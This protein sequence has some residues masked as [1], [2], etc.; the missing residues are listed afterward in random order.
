MD[1][2]FAK[3]FFSLNF[4]FLVLAGCSIPKP[5]ISPDAVEKYRKTLKVDK[6]HIQISYL[7]NGD[8]N[9][10][11][12]VM[13]HGT[14][15]AST[16]WAD[17]IQ[18][19]PPNSKVIAIDRPGFGKS[20]SS[21]SFSKLTDQVAA[22]HQIIP[23]NE[24]KITLIGH[25]LGGPIVAMYAAKYPDQV[26][27]VILLAGSFDPALEK[28]HP[29][30]YFADWF[31]VSPVLPNHIRNANEEL[32]ALKSELEKLTPLLSQIKAKI[33]IVHGDNDDLVPVDNVDFLKNHLTS[34]RCVETII[35]KGQNHFLPWNSE[36]IVRKAMELARTQ[37][38]N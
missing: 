24:S 5:A 37:V 33:I 12:F 28:I 31:L 35:I 11:L 4:L 17:Y 19:P 27:A 21:H 1:F 32:M 36:E 23:A 2:S 22:L 6:D 10:Q 9:G 26:Q 3:Y 25:S 15:G 16:G 7:E 30:Q 29:M 14:P 20:T 34:A 13:V 18:N 8:S 38:C